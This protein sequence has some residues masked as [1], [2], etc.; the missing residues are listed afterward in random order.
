MAFEPKARMPLP[1][2]GVNRR[3][4]CSQIPLRREYETM[5][6]GP[7]SYGGCML[8]EAMIFN[9]EKMGGPR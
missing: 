7:S 3:L 4:S 5:V 6:L 2:N 9:M 1:V 8:V